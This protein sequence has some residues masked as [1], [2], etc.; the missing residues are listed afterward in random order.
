MT[1]SEKGKIA[2]PTLWLYICGFLLLWEWLRP[3]KQLTDTDNLSVFIVFLVLSL[4]LSYFNIN[5]F[6]RNGIKLLYV[7]YTLNFLY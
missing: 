7:L 6:V 2:T 5:I 1:N 4:T 3:L